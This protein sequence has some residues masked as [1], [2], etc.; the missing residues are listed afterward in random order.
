MAGTLLCIN[1]RYLWL[2]FSTYI[3]EGEVER[4]TKKA[5]SS[6]EGGMV[7]ETVERSESKT[8][9]IYTFS[10]KDMGVIKWLVMN[11]CAISLFTG[12]AID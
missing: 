3:Y 9:A 7:H 2:I 5:T 1:V 10:K 8:T 4:V 12:D 11:D 6:S